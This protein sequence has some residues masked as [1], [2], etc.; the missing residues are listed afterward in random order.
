MA[1]NNKKKKPAIFFVDPEKC[2]MWIHHNRNYK[3]LDKQKCGSLMNSILTE[4]EQKFPA[5]VRR[6]TDDLE[7][8]YEVICGAR[9]HW[10]ISQLRK[11]V[12]KKFQ[13][14]IDVR[15]L[16]DEDAFRISDIENRQRVDI[17]HYERA[18]D[19]S[20]ALRKYYSSQ[21]EMA[22]KLG[23]KEA[24]LSRY[25]DIARLPPEIIG[26]FKNKNE[27]LP[28][29]AKKLKKALKVVDAK[30]EILKLASEIA[31]SK[32]N[33][34]AVEV[35][36]KLTSSYING[37][38][39]TKTGESCETPGTLSATKEDDFLM[40][41]LDLVDGKLRHKDVRDAVAVL[42]SHL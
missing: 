31:K 36:E 32:N 22:L 2:R 27:I 13:Y 40:L 10:V 4:G 23:V 7:Y 12:D 41:R 34:S 20:L 19:Y 17:S 9:R 26:C 16:S 42:N 33:L 39:A 35:V 6:L 38:T 3:A 1:N 28:G 11:Y 5:I 30:S 25:L 14:L 15:E 37:T 8:E 21:K 24:W 18:K 29:H